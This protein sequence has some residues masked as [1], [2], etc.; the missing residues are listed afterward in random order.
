V[1]FPKVILIERYVGDKGD[2]LTLA[3]DGGTVKVS[4]PK[5]LLTE[6]PALVPFTIDALISTRI[7]NNGN[8]LELQGATVAVY[9][10][11]APAGNG[12]K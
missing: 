2:Y 11:P 3:H 5:R 4:D 12:R 6:M 7:Y 9:G 8:V 10:E 1:R